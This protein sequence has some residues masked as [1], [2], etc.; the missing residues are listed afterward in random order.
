[1]TQLEIP[2]YLEA[3]KR[4]RLVRDAAFLGLPEAVAGFEL[5]QMT[6]RD[7]I[8]LSIARNPLLSGET[9]NPLEL[10]TFLWYMSVEYGLCC[11]EK[12]RDH[13]VKH[14]AAERRFFLKRCRSFQRPA[15]PLFPTRRSIARWE[16]SLQRAAGRWAEVTAACKEYIAETMQ[17]RPPGRAGTGYQPSYYSDACCLCGAIAREYSQPFSA[18]MDMPLKMIWQFVAEIKESNGGGKAALGNPS[19]RV[20]AAWTAAQNRGN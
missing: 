9:P 18:V 8:V 3:V 16:A 1:M 14:L 19:D 12:V 6:L 5:R 10:A 7:S 20:A 11:A 2:G 17:D 13:Q 4:E 15:P